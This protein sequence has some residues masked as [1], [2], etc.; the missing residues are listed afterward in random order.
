MAPKEVLRGHRTFEVKVN[1]Y[2]CVFIVR[3]TIKYG[4]SSVDETFIC[5]F[6]NNK[7]SFWNSSVIYHGGSEKHYSSELAFITFTSCC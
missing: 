4:H 1:F 6:A 2:L 5:N 3:Q 7:K